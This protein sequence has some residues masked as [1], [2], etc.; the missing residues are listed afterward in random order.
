MSNGAIK[1]LADENRRLRDLLARAAQ[2]F[3]MYAREHRLRGSIVKAETNEHF[4]DMCR[5]I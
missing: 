5:D 2:Q 3:G 1:T 4:R